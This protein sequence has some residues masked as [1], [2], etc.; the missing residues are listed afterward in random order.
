MFRIMV[1]KRAATE[2]S[3]DTRMP[4]WS[5]YAA[6]QNGDDVHTVVMQEVKRS[7]KVIP[8]ATFHKPIRM[9][10]LRPASLRRWRTQPH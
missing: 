8:L 6:A 4:D 10:A 5:A 7:G 2:Y 9:E 1:G 3:D